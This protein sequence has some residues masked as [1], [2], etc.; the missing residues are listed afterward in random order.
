ML[1]KLRN[2]YYLAMLK[3]PFR[4]ILVV[5]IIVLYKSVFAATTGGTSTSARYSAYDNQDLV[6]IPAGI[7]AF[8]IAGIPFQLSVGVNLSPYVSD[9]VP[10][11]ENTD[12]A[13][14]ANYNLISSYNTK[15]Q[16]FSTVNM[17]TGIA[18]ITY[19]G[20]DANNKKFSVMAT[21]PLF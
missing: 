7:N 10:G 15:Y 18:A 19:D 5:A 13:D 16:D 14:R 4:I 9:L 21:F 6:Y 20:S 2:L 12:S 8:T 17:G 11:S 3:I 1:K